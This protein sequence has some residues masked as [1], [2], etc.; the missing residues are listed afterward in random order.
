MPSGFRAPSATAALPARSHRLRAVVLIVLLLA[1]AACAIDPTLRHGVSSEASRV[2]YDVFPSYAKVAL[3]DAVS[4]GAGA[5][6]PAQLASN[7]TVYWYTRAVGAGAQ[8]LG[9]TVAPGFTGTVA[10]LAFTPLV[11]NAQ[12]APGGQASPNP[13]RLVLTSRPPSTATVVE[14]SDPPKFQQVNVKIVRPAQ[15]V[16]HLVATDPGAA[17]SACAE[18]GVVLYERTG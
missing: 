14:L 11:A 2:R 7:D 5:C 16:L 4:S 9:L 1:V 12:A 18:T 6:G 17:S 13:E 3:Q 15:V 8:V 10:K